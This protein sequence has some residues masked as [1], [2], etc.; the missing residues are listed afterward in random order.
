[1]WSS[2][3]GWLSTNKTTVTGFLIALLGNI[4]F[5]LK[6]GSFDW[7]V[8]GLGILVFIHG[9]LTK[10]YN[11]SNSPKPLAEAKPVDKPVDK[12]VIA[13]DTPH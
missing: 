2:F 1:M 5:Y 6:Q 7:R 12:P 10:D 4:I 11:V 3:K 13:S 9:Y 8:F